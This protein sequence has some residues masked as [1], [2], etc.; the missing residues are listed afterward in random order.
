[1]QVYEAIAARK[2]VRKYLPKPVEPEK[3]N[4]VLEAGRDAPSARNL[5]TWR[6]VVVQDKELLEKLVPACG[7]QKFV[8][9][10]T[11]FLAVCSDDVHEMTCNQLA[12]PVDCS[13]ALS[14]MMLRATEVG[15]STCW[16]GHFYEDQVKALLNIPAE[17][18]VIAV[19]PLGYAAEEP[20]ARPRKPLS[21]LVAY[22]DKW[23]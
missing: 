22:E 5:Q 12:A 8:G 23:L 7:N 18:R 6:F 13:I 21:E 9:E 14:F 20:A 11:A 1:M 2:S 17:Y 10:A 16:L 3:L 4:A 15:L 19:T